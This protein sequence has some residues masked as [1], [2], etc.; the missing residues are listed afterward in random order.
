MQFSMPA[1][2]YSE[3]NCVLNHGAEL[4]SLG[5]RALI[6]T[7]KSSARRRLSAAATAVARGISAPFSCVCPAHSPQGMNSAA[8]FFISA[9]M[10]IFSCTVSLVP[11]KFTL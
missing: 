6:V 8:A 11:L 4:A 1:L 10:S 7:G 5:T 9:S 2:V 3:E